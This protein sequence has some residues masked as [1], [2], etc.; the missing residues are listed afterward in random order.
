MMTVA[1]ARPSA[2]SVTRPRAILAGDVDGGSVTTIPEARRRRGDRNGSRAIAG[3]AADRARVYQGRS[4]RAAPAV[5]VSLSTRAD[6]WP[7]VVVDR[8]L[9]FRILHS[10]RRRGGHHAPAAHGIVSVPAARTRLQP[11]NYR[12]LRVPA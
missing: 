11:R 1:S 5:P 3:A 8:R 9:P 10:R 4:G 12:Q 2:I 6:R 7:S